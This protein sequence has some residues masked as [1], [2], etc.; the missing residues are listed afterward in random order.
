ML[1]ISF[2]FSSTNTFS[3]TLLLK[4]DLQGVFFAVNRIGSETLMPSISQTSDFKST[5]ENVTHGE[6]MIYSFWKLMD[7]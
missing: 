1:T 7:S 3:S 6:H 4:V 5:T 2:S